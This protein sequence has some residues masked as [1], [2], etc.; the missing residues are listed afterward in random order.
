MVTGAE[1]VLAAAAWGCL[2]AL[3]YNLHEQRRIAV[4]IT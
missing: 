2:T 3:A 4:E 1:S